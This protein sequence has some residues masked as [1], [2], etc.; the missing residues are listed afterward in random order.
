[1]SRH[2]R[3]WLTRWVKRLLNWLSRLFSRAQSAS[4]VTP[5]PP[6]GLA[7]Q[8]TTTG[9]R[10][11]TVG[12]VANGGQVQVDQSKRTLNIDG[13]A[14]GNTIV[15]GDGNIYHAA[16]PVPGE[17]NPFGVP[18]LRNRYFAGRE[19]VLEQLHE[20]LLQTSA[21]AMTQVQAISGLGGIGKTQTAVEY[22]YRYHLDEPF[23]TT[24]FW[25]TADTAVNLATNF[26]AI[27]DQLALPGAQ[28]LIQDDKI[29]AVRA[30][31]NTH[32]NWLLIFDNADRPDWLTAW[33]PAN[34]N[35][36]VLLTSRASEFAHLGIDEPIALDVLSDA[37]ALTL[38]FARTGIAR[39]AATV[40]EAKALNQ[41]LDGL[42]LAL[43]QASAYIK[44]QKLSDFARYLR[45]FERQG[46]RQLEKASPQTGNYPSSVLQ[47]WQLNVDAVQANNPAA[48]ALLELSAFL[49]PDD[50]PFSILTAGASHL[51]AELGDFLQSDDRNDESDR[52]LALRELLQ[53]LN[54]YSLV[55]WAASTPTYRVHRLVQAVVRDQLVVDAAKGWVEQ[56][57]AAIAAA[58]PGSGFGQW[59]V[60]RLLLPHWLTVVAQAEQQQYTSAAL[61]LL[62][63][64]AG[65]FLS[66]QGRY[67]EAEPLYRQALEII[68]TELGERH[69]INMFHLFFT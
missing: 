11:V 36:K 54:D 6:P 40:A 4:S 66:E 23:Y 44:A 8:Q 34:A 13:A 47:T 1:M 22:A 21:A 9:D 31:L 26:S 45:A 27:A 55:Q 68:R 51:G 60:C 5:P 43:E 28:S 61:G 2:R 48:R 35:G 12:E 53:L 16:P 58:Y 7:I 49:A 17:P 69:H 37:A 46:L 33:M 41:Q 57:I 10:N 25:V 56:A 38:L 3:S 20:Q 63:N 62:C 29:T 67:S 65:Y 32:P 14:Q 64:Q 30:W 39:S 52:T 18:Y 15:V 19:A 42:P 59:P 24:V 50:I